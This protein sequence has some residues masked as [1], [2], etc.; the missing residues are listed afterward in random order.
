[1][2]THNRRKSNKH[3]FVFGL[4]ALFASM[5]LLFANVSQAASGADTGSA[6][7]IL[8]DG[9]RAAWDVESPEMQASFASQQ[10]IAQAGPADCLG[11]GFRD[12]SVHSNNEIWL[13]GCGEVFT[14]TD[15]INDPDITSAM[16]EL[17]NATN[18]TWLLKY[19]LLLREGT[20]L[21]LIGDS[22]DVNWLRMASDSSTGV[23]LKA[24][25]GNINIQDT[26]ITS[27]DDGAGAVD[28]DDTDNGRAY[29]SLQSRFDG[30]ATAAATAC[31]VN[32]GTQEPY[33]SRLDIVNSE[34][35]YLGYN[36]GE[37]YGVSMKVYDA[38]GL[39]PDRDIYEMVD[40]FGSIIDSTIHDNYFGAYTFGAY[41]MDVTGN[42][43][44]DNI[45]YGFDP[46]DDSDHIVIDN[47]IMRRNGN[48]GLICSKYC[49]NLQIT[50][51]QT[52]SNLGNGIM[53]HREVTDS[54]LQNNISY[55]N[56]DSGIAVFD[57]YDNI[58]D[59]N[60]I[61]NNAKAGIRFS[62]G[63]S[64]NTITNNMITS[65]ELGGTGDG[66]AIYLY[67]G[68][69][70]TSEGGTKKPT[71][72]LFQNNVVVGYHSPI[73]Y[74]K[75][76][77]DNTFEDGT[78]EGKAGSSMTAFE[79]NP[80][81]ANRVIR[82]DF[83]DSDIAVHVYT[84]NGTTPTMP[85]A[86]SYLQ[87][88][89][90]GSTLRFNLH[91]APTSETTLEDT[92]NY[93]WRSLTNQLV[94]EAAPTMTT[95]DLEFSEVGGSEDVTLLDFRVIP[96]VGTVQVKPSTWETVAPY[97]KLWEEES[98][99]AGT[100][101]VQHIVGDLQPDTCYHVTVTSGDLGYYRAS[102]EGYISF[103]YTNGYASGTQTFSMVETPSDPSCP[104][105]TAV[106]GAE[107]SSTANELS[108]VVMMTVSLLGFAT[109]VMLRRQD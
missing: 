108:V 3:L 16:L 53:I 35:G 61:D 15:I 78:Y 67:E 6:E 80:G 57:S 5:L 104:V 94:T 107:L 45:Q 2:Y 50:N 51:N 4:L 31:D 109:L 36:A 86:F 7:S 68:S 41:C 91:S 21:N 52:Y 73:I 106:T 75:E 92:R 72:N 98:T 74:A 8:Q 38:T 9:P 25:N 42:K 79:F 23:W 101:N 62:V 26:K 55:L 54:L 10:R 19:N 95:L 49:D 28:T 13:D 84:K 17:S 100:D 93:V 56:G 66:Y 71:N 69:D 47:N 81:Y 70:T 46:H 34:I 44:E 27:W 64:D 99:D 18:K 37:S 48:H 103:P 24:R 96:T 85:M 39:V 65:L 89:V 105:P 22:G 87:D 60:T 1:M 11:E 77:Q 12:I 76:A 43:F 83:V 58:I 33:E 20:T 102:S 90:V 59:N 29:I 63:A 30:R 32:G 14:L 88:M 40:I 82:P 97:S